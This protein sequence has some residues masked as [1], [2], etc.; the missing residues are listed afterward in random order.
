MRTGLLSALLAFTCAVPATACATEAENRAGSAAFTSRVDLSHKG[1]ITVEPRKP[2]P[3]L[4]P[5]KQQAVL[6]AVTAL[7]THQPTP[8]DFKPAVGADIPRAV[9]IHGFPPRV[10]DE[11]PSL[12]NHMYAHLDREIMIV[13][14]LALKAVT[15]IP[16]P[17]DRWAKAQKSTQ[18]AAA[19]GGLAGLSD[20]QLR[21]I[22]QGISAAGGAAPA[23]PD[24][25]TLVVGSKIP[26]DITLNPLPPDIGR[27]V[28]RVRGLAYAK[29]QDQRVLLADPQ[30]RNV[31]GVITRAEGTG[32]SRGGEP[33]TQT[34]DPLRRL[35]EDGNASAYTGPHSIR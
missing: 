34:R 5:Q 2:A 7:D 3:A 20:E 10:L 1:P 32:K 13:D 19:V 28:P 27:Q 16:L 15:L 18:E 30:T 23:G 35:E 17:Q 9:N 24:G 4:S 33:E 29:L 14:A 31:V 22:Y 26:P 12:K 21:G 11:L 8:R 25:T 6:E